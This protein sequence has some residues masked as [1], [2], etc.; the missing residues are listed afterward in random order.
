MCAGC[1]TFKK[2][3]YLVATPKVGSKRTDENYIYSFGERVY[4]E[5]G[6]WALS[7]QDGWGLKFRNNVKLT[8]ANVVPPFKTQIEGYPVLN[9]DYLFCLNPTQTSSIDVSLLDVSQINS[10]R[11]L[12]SLS[13]YSQIYGIDNWTTINVNNMESMFSECTS[14]KSVDVSNLNTSNVTSMCDMF[15]RCELIESLDVS[16]FD[17][18]KVTS[19][20]S[21]FTG[22]CKLKHVNLENFDTSKVTNFRYMFSRC[23]SLESLNCSGF[24]VSHTFDM[25]FAFMGCESL[26]SLDLPRFN[27]EHPIGATNLCG[28]LC[29]C[30]SIEYLNLSTINVSELA[31]RTIF[32]NCQP[33]TILIGTEKDKDALINSGL[34]DNTNIVLPPKTGTVIVKDNIEYRFGLTWNGIMWTIPQDE[35]LAWGVKLTP[36]T[37]IAKVK[38]VINR[39]NVVVA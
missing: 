12:F 8:G 29:G 11:S 19:M 37:D 34:F 28:I 23:F 21:M 3:D 16:K 22:C 39:F 26:R 15:R 31:I 20:D 25:S 27:A 30:N 24:D 6:H 35:T 32:F 5:N 36:D 13:S 38:N 2:G 18:S 4:E 1:F 14:L 7:G 10:M 33:K 9:M 17:T